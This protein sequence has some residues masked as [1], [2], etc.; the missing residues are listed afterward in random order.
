MTGSE[1]PHP[2][3][4]GLLLMC[5]HRHLMIQKRQSMSSIYLE[6]AFEQFLIRCVNMRLLV[7]IMQQ[8]LRTSQD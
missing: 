3:P 5:Q 7:K 8:I 2:I 4:A 6:L 1:F